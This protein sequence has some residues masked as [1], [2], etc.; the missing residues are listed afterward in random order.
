[1]AFFV[2]TIIG[3]FKDISGLL[4]LFGIT[5]G[6]GWSSNSAS[7]GWA[8]PFILSLTAFFPLSFLAF[9]EDFLASDP[10]LT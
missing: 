5:Y 4:L 2:P 8:R 3:D 7:Y 9:S 10:Y 1:M 6:Y